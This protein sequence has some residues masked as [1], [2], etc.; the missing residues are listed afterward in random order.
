MSKLV[1]LLVVIL[2]V[3]LLYT[4]CDYSLLQPQ[5]TPTRFLAAPPNSKLTLEAALGIILDQGSQKLEVTSSR[6]QVTPGRMLLANDNAA[7]FMKDTNRGIMYSKVPNGIQNFTTT[8]PRDGLAVY[9]YLD[10]CLGTTD[11]ANGGSKCVL[12]WASSG[13]VSINPANTTD[14]YPLS[15]YGY[16]NVARGSS[17]IYQKDASSGSGDV[18]TSIYSQYG[19]VSGAYGFMTLSDERIKKN[20]HLSTGALDVIDRIKIVQYE[21]I[22]REKEKEVRFGV[23]AQQ[24]RECFPTAVR[25]TTDWIPNVYQ[26][27][28]KQILSGGAVSLF[29]KDRVP[30]ITGKL[31]KLIGEKDI[32]VRV[33]AQGTH[34]LVVDEF[35]IEEQLFAYGTREDDF[36]VVDKQQLGVLAIQGIKELMEEVRALRSEVQELKRQQ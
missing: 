13:S 22:D 7:L 16:T 33:L 32:L 25:E 2:S 4:R 31:L 9:G 11:V 28:E 5:R 30:P 27:V 14:T 23:V 10:G 35:P 19:V 36:L 21:H 29:F 17:Y 18:R 20:I 8:A 24:L 3:L 1:L 26:P 15:V 34:S 12:R 6:I